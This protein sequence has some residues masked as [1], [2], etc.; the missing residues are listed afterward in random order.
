MTRSPDPSAVA[1]LILARLLPPGEKGETRDKLG[2]DLKP[3]VQHRW[4][5]SVWTERLDQTLLDLDADG[6]ILLTRKGKT[7]R[8]ALTQEGRHVALDALGLTELPPKTTWAKLKSPYLLGRALDADPRKLA[9]ATGLKV[10]LLRRR[11]QLA[12]ND[13]P[14]MKQA[15]DA[16]AG[17][18]MGLERGQPF[19]TDSILKK[20]LSQA[21]IPLRSGQKPTPKNI[22]EAL[23]RRELGDSSAKSPVDLLVARNIGARQGKT[24]E[25]G[26][27]A[28]RS[29]IDRSERSAP[30][31]SAPA[32]TPS[33][34]LSDFARRILEAAPACPDGWFGD[35]KVFISRVWKSVRDD[36]GFAGVDLDD[37][38]RRLVEAHRARLLELGRADLVEAMD[39][40]SVQESATTDMGAVYHFLRAE[41]GTS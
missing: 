28:L 36:P 20:L 23:L 29:W 2:K 22:Q 30:Q 26:E 8:L 21:G 25:L 41:R 18:L 31:A 33:L 34:A 32:P 19:T 24:A 27:A 11:Y 4:E 9:T 16:L 35:G 5:G 14:T 17:S 37:F 12:L 15:T 3:L 10:E 40:A 1:L 39:P 7:E 38:K 6:L 13:R